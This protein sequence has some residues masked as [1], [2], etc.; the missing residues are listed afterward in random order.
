MEVGGKSYLLA[1]PDS[2][3]A[4]I[5]E[6]DFDLD[7]RLPY[8]AVVWPSAIA[9]ARYI[10]ER[11]LSGKK[12]VELGCGVGLPSVAALDRGAK[13]TATD[14]YVMALDFA[15]QNA[16]A[17]TGRELSTAHL[18]WHLPN[19]GDLDRFDFVIAADVLYEQRNVPALVG[20]IPDLLARGG[21]VLV[22]NPRRRDTPDFHE[23]MKAKGFGHTTRG[24]AT[25]Q[26]ERDVEVL[27]HRFQ[28]G[29]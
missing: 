17:S 13:V 21:E 19:T 24:A 22:S 8:W 27:V 23:A 20:L 6:E 14:H 29:S 12:V 5:D 25:R 2:A 28:G 10:S 9:L 26:G 1:H 3:E 18:D 7:E 11:D 4:L 15:R 16:K